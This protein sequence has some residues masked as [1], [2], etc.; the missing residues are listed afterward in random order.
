MLYWAKNFP[1]G[2]G[3][4]ENLP[5]FTINGPELAELEKLFNVSDSP[6]NTK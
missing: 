4:L 3:D 6:D 1:N 5:A 2:A